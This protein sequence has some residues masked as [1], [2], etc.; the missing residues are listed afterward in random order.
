M[1]AAD[2]QA[3]L[4]EVGRL[5]RLHAQIAQIAMRTDDQRQRNLIQLRRQLAEQIGRVGALSEEFFRSARDES[6]LGQ[7]RQQFSDM[8]A[9]TAMH[10][11]NWPAF[12][13]V[14]ASDEYRKSSQA[15]TESIRAFIDWARRA[16]A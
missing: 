6:K 14:E 13:L 1:S 10:Q 3:L 7:F 12:R 15:V 5:E 16:V 11:A 9:K 8:R 4:D 2:R